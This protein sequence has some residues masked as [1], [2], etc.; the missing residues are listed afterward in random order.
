[1]LSAQI[2]QFMKNYDSGI[3]YQKIAEGYNAAYVLLNEIEVMINS[4]SPDYSDIE[5]QLTYT[6]YWCRRKIVDRLEKYKWPDAAPIMIPSMSEGPVTLF[7]ANKNT[8]ERLTKIAEPLEIFGTIIDFLN[9]GEVFD[10]FE[11]QLPPE[12]KDMFS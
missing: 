10:E 12:V 7:F 1:M 6:A 4:V 9:R 5:K 8:I 11:S 3:E 2:N